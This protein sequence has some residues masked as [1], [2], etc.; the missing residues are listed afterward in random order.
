MIS[1]CFNI[2]SKGA[3]KVCSKIVSGVFEEGSRICTPLYQ[4]PKSMQYQAQEDKKEEWA[5]SES[6]TPDVDVCGSC[7]VELQERVRGG[8]CANT[9]SPPPGL[10]VHCANGWCFNTRPIN[11]SLSACEY[12]L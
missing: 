4:Y 2:T 12:D 9:S 3:V 5:K 10:R 6:R 7:G 1:R 8:P 11:T